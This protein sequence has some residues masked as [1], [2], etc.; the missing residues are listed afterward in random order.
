MDGFTNIP[1]EIVGEIFLHCLPKDKFHRP[2]PRLAPILLTH[3]CRS[4]RAF[5]RQYGSLWSS[6]QIVRKM[7]QESEADIELR[8][9]NDQ[10]NMWANNGGLRPLD[11]DISLQN[12][13]WHFKTCPDTNTS[14]FEVNA[15]PSLLS[16]F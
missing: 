14:T 4:W 2:D 3:V 1:N 13:F 7:V 16:N 5:A 9:I 15:P 11:V 12:I 6:I 10:L 8:K